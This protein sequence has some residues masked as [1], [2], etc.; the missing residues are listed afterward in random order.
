VL[1]PAIP[2]TSHWQFIVPLGPGRGRAAYPESR[3]AAFQAH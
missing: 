3:E 2:A 1:V